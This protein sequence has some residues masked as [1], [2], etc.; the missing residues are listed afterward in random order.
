MINIFYSVFLLFVLSI[1]S[2]SAP[3]QPTAQQSLEKDLNYYNRINSEINPT[4]NDRLY[5]LYKLRDKYANTGANITP[6]KQEIDKLEPI[7]DKKSAVAEPATTDPV[8]EDL[9]YYARI[10]SG[11]KLTVNDMLYILYK[12]REKYE[13]TGMDLTLIDNE[14]SKL[15]PQWMNQNRPV[16]YKPPYTI[17]SPDTSGVEDIKAGD[18]LGISVYPMEKFAGEVEVKDNGVVNLPLIGMIPVQGMSLDKLEEIIKAKIVRYV[19]NP[20]VSVSKHQ[21]IKNKIIVT[22]EIRNPGIYLYSEGSKI[23]DLIPLVGGYT[24]NADET[25]F[26]VHRENTTIKVNTKDFE[27]KTNDIIEIP[28]SDNDVTVIGLVE[29]PGDYKYHYG[30]TVS[31]VITI[32]GGVSKSVKS[33]TV[34]IMR[35]TKTSERAYYKESL[36]KILKGKND[37]DFQL[38]PGDIVLVP[39]K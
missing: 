31:E 19:S 12:I 3:V 4:V 28:R 34:E 26:K 36:K 18:I 38:E 35:K 14:L 33:D 1:C 21:N 29:K 7:R 39:R 30:M 5:L 13:G 9:N 23:S 16:V 10:S 27:L 8:Q 20:S 24:E 15:N 2:F 6:I 32:A 22:G 37:L 25:T 11:A 17:E